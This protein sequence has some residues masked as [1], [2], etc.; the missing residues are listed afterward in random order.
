M[1]GAPRTVQSSNSTNL[2]SGATFNRMAKEGFSEEG[3]FELGFE[4]WAPRQGPGTAQKEA[5]CWRVRSET[6]GGGCR[7]GRGLRGQDFRGL[8]QGLD[9]I[10]HT[11]ESK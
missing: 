7:I 1:K 6:A 8:G 3:T 9:F 2:W 10:P 4:G 11:L 5:M